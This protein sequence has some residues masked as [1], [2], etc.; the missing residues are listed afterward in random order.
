MAKGNPSG[1]NERAQH[2]LRVLV[3]QYIDNGQPVGSKALV[4]VAGLD[5]SP[6]TIRN[7]MADLEELGF[8]R[9]PHTSA[10]RVP[11]VQGYRFFV[12]GLVAVK[13]FEDRRVE[14]L[15]AQ[16]GLETD[17]QGVLASV[18]EFLS[19]IT[20]LAGMVT[21]PKLQQME[22]SHLEFVPLS[23]NR[24]LVIMVTNDREVQNRIVQLPRRFATDELHQIAAF[25]NSQ[26][27]GKQ[28]AQLRQDLLRDMKNARESMNQMMRA[29]VEMAERVF[30]QDADGD[31][32]VM[33]GQ[34]NLM[35][36]EELSNVHQL[37]QLF[38]AFNKKRDILHMLDQC[39]HGQGVQIFIGEESGY[40][41]F[42]DCSLV[43]SSY[44]VDGKILGV[45]GV[46]GPTR[47]AYDKVISVVDITAKVLGAALNSKA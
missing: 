20:R 17:T 44:A 13:P 5:L 26:F 45:L 4:K 12:D 11:T 16:L 42:G 29:A 39:L 47:M 41:A 14:D 24:V 43:T 21:V 1:L 30:E 6:A 35:T 34:T 33:V 9:S 27:R 7:I 10:G 38:E 31:G 8:L 25:L 22:L 15:R 40:Q 23:E 19:G 28:I 36:F 32:Y 3:Q 37:R 2:V 46:L 18:S